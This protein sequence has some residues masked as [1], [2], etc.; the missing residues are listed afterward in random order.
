MWIEDTTHVTMVVTEPIENA[1]GELIFSDASEGVHGEDSFDELLSLDALLIAMRICAACR[2]LT[3]LAIFESTTV[4]WIYV[5]IGIT[6]DASIWNYV[7]AV[8]CLLPVVMIFI[9]ACRYDPDTY[10]VGGFVLSLVALFLDVMGVWYCDTECMPGQQTQ[11][12]LDHENTLLAVQYILLVL[13]FVY[14]FVLGFILAQLR[15]LSKS[16]S[17]S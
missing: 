11:M 6:D 4:L 14:L 2:G 9:W 16:I 3:Y 17:G 12:K 5:L 13:S 7:M 10:A 15:S 1:I 8:H